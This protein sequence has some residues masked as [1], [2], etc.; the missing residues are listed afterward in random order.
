VAWGDYDNDGDLDILLTGSSGFGN[1]SIAAVYRN[2]NG[3]FVDSGVADDALSGIAG[4]GAA[5]GDYDNDGDLDILLA[6]NYRT[7]LY[8]NDDGIFVDSGRADD[9]LAAVAEASVAWGDY[10]SD[11]DLDILLT[12]FT[13]TN[14]AKVYRN[15][16]GLFVDSGAADDA[17]I[18]VR[19]S[20]MAAWGDYDNDGDLDIVL[21]GSVGQNV[22]IAKVYRNDNGTFV[23]S[24]ATLI[25][26]QS[27]AVAWGDYDNDGDLDIL[28]TGYNNSTN[29]TVMKIYRND[30]G[31]FVDS[32]TTDALAGMSGGSA[33]WGDYDN[34]GD[35]DIFVSGWNGTYPFA[36]YARLYRN[37][38]CPPLQPDVQIEKTV[39]PGSAIPGDTI[40]YTLTFSNSG[41]GIAEDVVIS[42]NVPV[43][44]TVD[45]VQWTLGSGVMI[46][47]TGSAPTLAW[48]VSDLPAGAG[49]AITLTGT[50]ST[51]AALNNTV[52]TNTATITASNDTISANNRSS[53]V[54]SVGGVP[55][56][57]INKIVDDVTPE[58]GNIITFTI[59]IS[60]TGNGSATGVEVGD[61]MAGVLASDVVLTAGQRLT[62][63]YN[64]AVGD[65][66][67]TIHN[68]ASVTSAQTAPVSASVIVTVQN[69]APTAT[70]TN[71]GPVIAGSPFTLSLINVVDPA[72]TDTFTYRFDCGDGNGYTAWAASNSLVCPTSAAAVRSVKGQVKDDD[73]G[74]SPEYTAT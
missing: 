48:V 23:D 8:R 57:K 37:D 33:V 54:V 30:A 10:D 7:T 68:T 5:W 41:T 14:I 67:R 74:A 45:N 27:G 62:Y 22:G 25:D 18:G 70:F 44:V 21:V 43:S 19:A 31:I 60:N 35:L 32:G 49:G 36:D 40:T 46:T 58:E 16:G 34:D 47:T 64:T 73:G 1:P 24:S 11:G 15:E 53:A 50:L 42:D 66:P 63:T 29:S 61:N 56:L 65:G 4:G 6:G 71:T 51:S 3:T 72:S 69:V 39:A 9:A 52:V 38:D 28:L 20:G 26:V 17:L 55:V 2:D 12:G 59:V 13:G